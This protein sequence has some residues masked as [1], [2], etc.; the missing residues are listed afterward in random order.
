[1][2]KF[3]NAKVIIGIV[4]V[5]GVIN[6]LLAVAMPKKQEMSD[7]EAVIAL[8]TAYQQGNYEEFKKYVSEDN[9][10]NHI[11]A[12]L[13]QENTEMAAVY[14]MVHEQTK[15]VVFTAEAVEGRERWGEVTVTLWNIDLYTPVQ[16]AMALAIEDQVTNGTDSFSDMPSWLLAGVKNPGET[17]KEEFTVHVGCSEGE[18]VLDTNSN[19]S[20]FDALCGYYY[21]YIDATMTTCTTKGD[22]YH[23]ASCGDEIVGMVETCEIPY[24]DGLTK[25]NAEETTQAYLDSCSGIDGVAAYAEAS[26]QAVLTRFGVDFNTASS[27]TLYNLGIVSDKTSNFSGSYLSLSSTISSFEESGMVCERNDFGSGVLDEK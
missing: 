5:L 16:E 14:Q 22:A 12:A 6:G 26:D 17:V 13:G 21:Q 10:L 27:T 11:M 9:Q 20:F 2:K 19:R 23:L 3:L 7:E 8:I 25:D 15:N 1:M 24:A 18:T 4:I